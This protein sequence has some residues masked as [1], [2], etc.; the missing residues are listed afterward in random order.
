[1]PVS[2]HANGTHLEIEDGIGA[3]GEDRAHVVGVGG[4]RV[5]D[6]DQV[7]RLPGGHVL[8]LDILQ[9]AVIV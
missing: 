4:A 5:V 9:S 2:S 3:S 1:M 6:V 7:G 8:Q